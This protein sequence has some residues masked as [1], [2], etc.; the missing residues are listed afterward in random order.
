[1][2]LVLTTALNSAIANEGHG[3]GITTDPDSNGIT[4]DPTLPKLYPTGI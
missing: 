2:G 4:A 3:A 1:M